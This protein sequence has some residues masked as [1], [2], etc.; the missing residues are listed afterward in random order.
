MSWAEDMSAFADYFVE[1]FDEGRDWY[2]PDHVE[3]QA[4]YPYAKD[5][6]REMFDDLARFADVEEALAGAHDQATALGS[7]ASAI[8]P[9][10]CE[11]ILAEMDL[12]LENWQ[13][14]SA[15]NFRSHMSGGNGMQLA[16]ANCWD[17]LRGAE[18]A[19]KAY[20][21]VITRF[22]DDV[23]EFVSRTQDGVEQAQ[24]TEQ[25]ITMTLVSAAISV[26][27]AAATAG[28][29]AAVATTVLSVGNALQGGATGMSTYMVGGGSKCKIIALMPWEGR[30]ILETA[31]MEMA[32]VTSAFQAVAAGISGEG[33]RELR[34]S[35]PD[36]VTDEAFDPDDFHREGQPAEV[37][38]RVSGRD[39]VREPDRQRPDVPGE[40]NDPDPGQDRPAERGGEVDDSHRG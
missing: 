37:S 5:D 15:A 2:I 29:S 26:G 34:P 24:E 1:K 13:G 31:T 35:R 7:A 39:L 27:T 6:V 16:L 38:D 30:A 9:D 20:R 22:R 25:K 33:L 40:R 28:A 17:R 10:L 3:D 36:L 14:D 32:K 18:Y 21:E 8:N 23:L 4:N 19:L 12:Y 11:S